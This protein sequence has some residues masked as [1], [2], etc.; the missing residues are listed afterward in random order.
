MVNFKNEK[1][2]KP[3]ILTEAGKKTEKKQKYFKKYTRIKNDWM[4]YAMFLPVLVWYIVFCYA[5]MGGLVLSFKDYSYTKG[6]WGSEWIGLKNFVTMFKDKGMSKAILNTLYFSAVGIPLGICS[7]VTLAV[8]LNELRMPRGKK[9]IQTAVTFP[10][11]ISWV[12]L[13][14][15]M[16]NVFSSHGIVNALL[17]MFGHEKVSVLT[18]PKMYRGFV[19]LSE[20]WKEVGWGSII[21]LAAITSIDQGLY[22][23]A[24]IDGATRL[25]RI[26][27]VTLP[28]IRSTICIML[29][30]AVGGAITNGRFDQIY[31]TYSPV[32][33]EVGDTLDTYIYRS[34]FNEGMDFGY[35]TAIGMVK[36]V[37]GMVMLLVA[38]KTVTK[39]GEQ[40]IF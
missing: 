40:G 20:V 38:N 14:G 7:E 18:S 6:V 21:Y 9:F 32:V 28:S 37:I 36:S 22:E 13:S 17:G 16:I 29:I 27:H 39:F 19:W 4:L 10:H 31:N 24:H 34:T 15:I 35:S 12:V 5:P 30:L 25:Q 11:F 33:Y 3:E 8:M 26:W 23:A 1:K 2:P